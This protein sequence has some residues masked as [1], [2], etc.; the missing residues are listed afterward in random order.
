MAQMKYYWKWRKS[1]KISAKKKYHKDLERVLHRVGKSQT[2]KFT[3]YDKK[4]RKIWNFK[5][6]NSG[7]LTGFTFLNKYFCDFCLFPKVWTSG[8]LESFIICGRISRWERKF[9][10]RL[11]KDCRFEP[12]KKKTLKF[13][14]IG[15]FFAKTETENVFSLKFLTTYSWNFCIL[16]SCLSRWEILINF[17]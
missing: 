8:R 5:M 16:S 7:Q 3:R 10:N 1:N 6:K 13:N 15:T 4:W 11:E 17:L 12:I 2:G 9:W 14:K